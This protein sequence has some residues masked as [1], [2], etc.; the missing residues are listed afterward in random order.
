MALFSYPTKIDHN[1]IYDLE[2]HIIDICNSCTT[3]EEIIAAGTPLW[4]WASGML[5]KD[6]QTLRFEIETHETDEQFP[7]VY[8]EEKDHLLKLPLL[9]LKMINNQ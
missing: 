8:L 5:Q 7:T 6:P 1:V 2:N 3:A 4:D 9:F